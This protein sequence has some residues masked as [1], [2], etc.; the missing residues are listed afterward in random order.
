MLPFFMSDDEVQAM[1]LEAAC[2]T[3]G[4]DLTLIIRNVQNTQ[5]S[6]ARMFGAATYNGHHFTYFP[7]GDELIRDDVLKWLTKRREAARK[8][9]KAAAKAAQGDLI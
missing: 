7:A 5:L 6:I 9:E 2:G 1:G 3:F 8:A 4:D